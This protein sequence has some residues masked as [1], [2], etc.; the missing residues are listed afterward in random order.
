MVNKHVK[1]Q[2][3]RVL[4]FSRPFF[5]FRACITGETFRCVVRSDFQNAKDEQKTRG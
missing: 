1:P 2:K 3:S 4:L 5:E